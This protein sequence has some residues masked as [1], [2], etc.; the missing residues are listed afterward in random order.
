M[1][2][3]KDTELAAGLGVA[4]GLMA[5]EMVRE[6]AKKVN[7]NCRAIKALLPHPSSLMTVGTFFHSFFYP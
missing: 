6:A 2:T 3:K 4:L 5:I 7:F 1:L